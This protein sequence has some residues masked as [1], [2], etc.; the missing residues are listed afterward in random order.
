MTVMVYLYSSNDSMREQ[1]RLAH[2]SVH[3]MCLADSQPRN[4]E[5]SL[6]SK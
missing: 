3:A 2:I 6:E 1:L 5:C 4:S